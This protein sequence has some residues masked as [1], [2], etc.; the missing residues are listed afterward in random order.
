[1]NGQEEREQD[2]PH[3]LSQLLGIPD[4]G[5][6]DPDPV[7]FGMSIARETFPSEW[8]FIVHLQ[9]CFKER[10]RVQKTLDLLEEGDG[11]SPHLQQDNSMQSL[12]RLRRF[13]WL[14]IRYYWYLLL[15][16]PLQDQGPEIPP[17]Q[18]NSPSFKV[19]ILNE[20][21]KNV[22][23]KFCSYHCCPSSNIQFIE[24]FPFSQVQTALS[25]SS[26][27]KGANT[28]LPLQS[29]AITTG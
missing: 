3:V 13:C 24:E 29:W 20:L 11:R 14:K 7:Y 21:L 10:Q 1:M 26:Q 27:E 8:H 15:I 23:V 4:W 6:I 2:S 19:M 16:F 17:R 22:T 28:E 25:S 9:K 18:L 12:S 5:F